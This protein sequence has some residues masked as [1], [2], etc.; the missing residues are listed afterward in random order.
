MTASAGRN[1][2]IRNVHTMGGVQERKWRSASAS[3]LAPVLFMYNYIETRSFRA[4]SNL[5]PNGTLRSALSKAALRATHV[6]HYTR[7]SAMLFRA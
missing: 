1:Q 4:G 7:K 3:G 2:P 5:T 6:K